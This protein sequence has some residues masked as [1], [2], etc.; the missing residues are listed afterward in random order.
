MAQRDEN[1]SSGKD[2]E[3]SVL[4][5]LAPYLTMGFQLGATV[6]IFFFAGHWLDGQFRTAPWCMIVLTLMGIGGALY[7]FFT[8]VIKLGKREDERWKAGKHNIKDS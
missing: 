7:K 4:R 5:Q 6:I 1:S 2:S 3:H 8:T